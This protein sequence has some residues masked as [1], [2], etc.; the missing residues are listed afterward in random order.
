M[1]G[2]VLCRPIHASVNLL[3]GIGK[4]YL[5]SV[6]DTYGSLAFGFLHTSKQPEAAV[7]VLHNDVRH[8]FAVFVLP[9]YQERQIPLCTERAHQGYRNGGNRPLDT[10]NAFL[11]LPDWRTGASA[12]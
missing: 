6:V 10:V 4:V 5:H 1:P 7:A 8:G 9:F 3:K 11:A 2:H 12:V